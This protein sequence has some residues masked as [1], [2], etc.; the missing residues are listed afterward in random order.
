M[1][2]QPQA[3]AETLGVLGL[4]MPVRELARRRWDVIVVG[5]GHNHEN[6]GRM[7]HATVGFCAICRYWRG[8][9][10]S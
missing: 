5:A 3:A 4:P 2:N 10:D 1:M 8:G 6:L 9:G 7:T